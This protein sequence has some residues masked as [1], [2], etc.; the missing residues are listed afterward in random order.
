VID[1]TVNG[2]AYNTLTRTGW[3]VNGS[4]TTW[5][6]KNPGTDPNGFTVVGVKTTPSKPGLVKLK[7]KGKNG[8]YAV[9]TNHLPLQTTFI[10]DPPF[11]STGECVEAV[12]PATFPA[13]PSCTVASAGGTVKCK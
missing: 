9:H 7:V 10:L 2:G 6:Y 5:T 11:A 13:K 12:W 8:A 1:A 3:K 4:H